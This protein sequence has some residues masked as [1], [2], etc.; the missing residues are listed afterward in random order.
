M[1]RALRRVPIRNIEGTVRRR[2]GLLVCASPSTAP[3]HQSHARPSRANASA[4]RPH[5]GGRRWNGPPPLPRRQPG[6]YLTSAASTKA[7]AASHTAMESEARL[8][9]RGHPASQAREAAHA[10]ASARVVRSFDSSRRTRRRAS[11][12]RLVTDV[13]AMR[14]RFA[15]SPSRRLRSR[16]HGL[17]H[18]CRLM[19]TAPNPSTTR[20]ADSC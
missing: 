5:R 4:R 11:G 2:R 17:D 16:H 3:L 12:P 13:L 7:T 9:L 1:T 20:S 18:Q 15:C 8:P 6:Q 19:R 14:A 10:R